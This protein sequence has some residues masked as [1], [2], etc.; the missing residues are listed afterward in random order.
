MNRITDQRDFVSDFTFL[1]LLDFIELRASFCTGFRVT[2]TI[3][4][5]NREKRF[6]CSVCIRVGVFS[7]ANFA[8]VVACIIALAFVCFTW[9]IT[10]K[11]NTYQAFECKY[12]NRA[13]PN[14]H[15]LMPL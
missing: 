4:P 15:I 11:N 2:T 10:L 14:T 8:S 12:F 9:Q 1:K 3:T 7:H 6:T 5:R 13:S